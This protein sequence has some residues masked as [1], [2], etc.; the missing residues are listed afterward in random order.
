M[1]FTFNE[2][3]AIDRRPAVGSDTVA[4]R[5]SSEDPSTPTRQT[6]DVAICSSV[7]FVGIG[8]S[9]LSVLADVALKQGY[10]V[11]GSDVSDNPKAKSVR[12]AGATVF[13]GHSADNLGEG[14]H[15]SF[16]F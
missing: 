15:L 4:T 12:K 9:G 11:S 14:M 1:L 8:G 5:E 2:N 10:K 16:A 13:I 6:G 7:H 3:G